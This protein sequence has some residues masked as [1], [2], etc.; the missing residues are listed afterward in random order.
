MRKR[1]IIELLERRILY[2]ADAGLALGLAVNGPADAEHRLVDAAHEVAFIDARTPDYAAIVQDIAAQGGRQIDVVMLDAERDGLEQIAEALAGRE[3]VAALHIIAHGGDGVMQLGSDQVTAETLERNSGQVEGWRK[4]LTTEADIL[5]YGCDVAATAQGRLLADALARLTGADVAASSDKTGSAESGGD[6]D[7][8][9]V[10]GEVQTQVAVSLHAQ[11]LWSGVLATVT[12]TTTADL[13]DGNTS[14][15]AALLATP[16][17]DGKISLR[18]A[19]I[20]TNSTAG[21]DTISLAAGTYTLSRLGANEGAASTGDLDIADSLTINGAGART[22]FIDGAAADRVFEILGGPVTIS[23][24]TVQNGAASDGAGVRVEGSTSLTLRDVA[25]TGNVASTTGG[26]FFVSGALILDRVTIDGNSANTGAGIYINNLG[27]VSITNGTISGNTATSGGGALLVRGTAAITNATIAFNAAS[28]GAGGIEEAGSGNA[29]LRNTILANNT[30]GNA[31]GPLS[32]LGNNI[33]SGNTAGLSG[34]GDRINTDPLLGPLQYNGGE[35]KTHALLAGSPAINAAG[36]FG[37]PALDQRGY[38]RDAT[39]D[40]GAYELGGTPPLAGFWITTEGNVASPSG[41]K[42]LD[43]WVEGAVLQFSDPDLALEPGG[44]DGTLSLVFNIDQFAANGAAE[45]D[46]IHYVS[47]NITVAGM[48]LLAGDVLFSTVLIEDFTSSNTLLN[49]AD[50]DLVVFRPDVAGNYS[51]GTFLMLLDESAVSAANDWLDLGGISL[52]EQDTLVGDTMLPAGSFLLLE[53]ATAARRGIKLFTP[54]SVGATTDGTLQVLIDGVEA[55]LG[56]AFDGLDL[57][58]EASTV[59]GTTL[60]PGKILVSEDGSA[61]ISYLNVTTTELGG[62]GVSAASLTL[63]LDGNA[64]GLNTANENIFA[65]TLLPGSASTNNAPTLTTF[66]APVDTTAE[67]TEVE[68]T[69]AELKAQGNE[70]DVDGTVDAFV[71]KAV[72]S[73]TLRIGATAGT[74]TAW[75]VGSNDT[76]DAANNAYWT[77]AS[78]ANGAL[79]A[80]TAVA[81][82]NNGAES[83]APVQA[84][85]GVTPV[86]DAPVL[87]AVQ[88]TVGEGG[89]TVL[90]AADFD[91]TDPDNAAFTYTVSGVAGGS[92]EVF[93]GSAWVAGTVFTTAQLAAGE[94]RFVDDGDEV[95]PSFSVTASDGTANSNTLAATV[96]YTPV[97]D[98]PVLDAVQL[99]VSEGGT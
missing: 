8:E 59:G 53:G 76:I 70:A 14:S 57:L 35:T 83:A 68:I 44:S 88:L 86:N 58:E 78:D 77:P 69:L 40:I 74:A 62:T 30:G 99:T 36:L 21:A 16:G 11:E 15:I 50:S 17:A 13:L 64:V 63:L 23:G 29:L 12:V 1:P 94:V 41:V 28:S 49:V 80:F 34:T 93:N 73:G 26:G 61:N 52:V 45:I 7:L 42:G 48:Q 79:N 81:K 10:L 56:G 66:A 2:S 75:A 60:S 20:A 32:S 91:V 37:A 47:R 84:Q 67:D 72:S 19:I 89:T 3:N 82:D 4:A 96:T 9:Y 71:V 85:V 95:A 6:W 27:N 98:A 22:T 24:L 65:L 97:N 46:A 5:L 51:A 33:D 43:S 18:E 90:A 31:G 87:D 38:T 92:F 25:V 39:P 54:D 55:G